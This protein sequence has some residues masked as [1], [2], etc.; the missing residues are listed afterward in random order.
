MDTVGKTSGWIEIGRRT[1]CTWNRQVRRRDGEDSHSAKQACTTYRT[2]A[3][4]RVVGASDVSASC[5]SAGVS[6]HAETYRRTT[7]VARGPDRIVGF[8]L[9]PAWNQVSRSRHGTSVRVLSRPRA[10]LTELRVHGVT[11][12]RRQYVFRLVLRQR[13]GEDKT[14]NSRRSHHKRGK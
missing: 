14:N 2:E 12:R 13:V 11:G 4:C 7:D 1:E 6:D 10:G 9:R 5:V 3:S 8:A